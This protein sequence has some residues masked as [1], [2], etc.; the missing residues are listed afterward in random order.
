MGNDKDTDAIIEALRVLA[1]IASA[2]DDNSLDDEA[3]KFWGPNDEHE[4]TTP[5]ERI[6]LF[7]GRGGRCL[8]TLADCLAARD[9]LRKINQVVI[10]R[11]VAEAKQ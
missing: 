9:V 11:V 1:N 2:Y 3:R 8:L 6:E 5:P 10:A 7:R 4:N